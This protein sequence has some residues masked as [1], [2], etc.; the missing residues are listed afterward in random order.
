MVHFHDT[1]T[2]LY[3]PKGTGDCPCILPPTTS[4]DEHLPVAFSPGMPN[5]ASSF[6]CLPSHGLKMIFLS[7]R[8]NFSHRK[9]ELLGALALSISQ[10]LFE[11]GHFICPQPSSFSLREEGVGL[12]RASGKPGLLARLPGSWTGHSHL[13]VVE[14]L[15][16]GS[17]CYVLSEPSNAHTWVY[18]HRCR[19]DEKCPNEK[20]RDLLSCN[21]LH[22]GN[23]IQRRQFNF[24]PDIPPPL[25]CHNSLKPVF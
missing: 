10:A 14:N 19:D 5:G 8:P 4:T 17:Q 3:V 23:L 9:W 20:F 21:Q 16:P 7:N 22:I 13:S 18:S 1:S 25:L 24:H 6:P 12:C 11:D 15:C 2:I